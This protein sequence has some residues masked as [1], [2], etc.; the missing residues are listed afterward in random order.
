MAYDKCF[1]N[2]IK[3]L[4]G[5]SAFK[6]VLRHDLYFFQQ[7]QTLYLL[8]LIGNFD[9]R[10]DCKCRFGIRHIHGDFVELNKGEVVPGAFRK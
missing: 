2:H 10:P 3:A 4:E 7:A 6:N 1:L 9:E 8:V 5:A